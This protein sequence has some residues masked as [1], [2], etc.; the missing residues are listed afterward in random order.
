MRR[1][2]SWI[3]WLALATVSGAATA[4]PQSHQPPAACESVAGFHR[5]DFWLGSWDVYVGEQKVGD[6]RIEKMLAGCAILEHWTDAE[7][8]E[9]KSFFFYVPA[10]DTWKQVWVTERATAPGGVKEKVL[11]ET[12]DDGGV[13]FQGEIPLEGGGRYF[14]RTTLTP[15]AEGRVG[16]HI[17]ISRDGKSWESTFDAVY[18]PK[19][20]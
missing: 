18:V 6:N 4:R 14:D 1:K 2:L 11:V 9:G 15:L 7:G 17:E 3:V 5:L 16:Q 13:R 19:T 20:K 12:F 8:N 10:T